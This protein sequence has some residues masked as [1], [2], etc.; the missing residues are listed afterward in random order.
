[1]PRNCPVKLNSGVLRSQGE[2]FCEAL[3]DKEHPYKFVQ[4]FGT[5]GTL[6]NNFS[7]TARFLQMVS[8]VFSGNFDSYMLNQLVEIE[9][10]N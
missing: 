8:P 1:M 4:D 9:I 3:L 7:S 6:S 10:L 2:S 5:S